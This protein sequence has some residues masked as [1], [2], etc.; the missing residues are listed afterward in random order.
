MIKR[1][2][3]QKQIVMEALTE[4][5][6]H[7]TASM[8]Y[9]YIHQAHPTISKS[10]VFRILGNAAEDGTIRKLHILGS[11]DRYDHKCH[12]HYHFVCKMCGRVID[13]NLPYMME[14]DQKV[15]R[16]YGCKTLG[17]E[18]EFTGLCDQCQSDSERVPAVEFVQ[19][20]QSEDAI[21]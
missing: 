16:I 6:N 1:N 8:V 5:D 12:R 2:T 17:H 15:S 21:I 14:M 18:M 7:P 9:E 13:L 3:P 4:M 19:D 10:T 11:D 20:A